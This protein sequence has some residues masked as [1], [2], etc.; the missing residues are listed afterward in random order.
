MSSVISYTRDNVCIQTL[1][2]YGA[3]VESVSTVEG[4]SVLTA[5]SGS[6]TLVGLNLSKDALTDVTTPKRLKALY[7]QLRTGDCQLVLLA[8]SGWED[9]AQSFF[10]ESMGVSIIPYAPLSTG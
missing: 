1:A 10:N 4:F 5:H 2:R 6:V 7:Q 8:Q 9:R 3:T